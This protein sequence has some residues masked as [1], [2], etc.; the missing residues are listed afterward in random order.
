MPGAGQAYNGHPFKALAFLLG[1]ALVLPW[2]GG[3]AEAWF[4]AR[5]ISS[6][7][8][9]AGRGGPIWIAMQAWAFALLGL[10]VLIGLTLGGVLE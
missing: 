8:G 10:A 9:R 3:A 1:S 6:E 5:R 4:A 2:I 7:G